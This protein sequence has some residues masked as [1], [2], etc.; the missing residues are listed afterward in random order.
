MYRTTPRQNHVP[1]MGPTRIWCQYWHH[2]IKPGNSSR[3]IKKVCNSISTTE[4]HDVPLLPSVQLFFSPQ[5][6]CR[7]IWEDWEVTVRGNAY[8]ILWLLFP[9]SL[10][11]CPIQACGSSLH[12]RIVHAVQRHSPPS[13]CPFASSTPCVRVARPLATPPRHPWRSVHPLALQRVAHHW[14]GIRHAPEVLGPRP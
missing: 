9:L 8:F 4:E 13:C 2:C 7:L 14:D 1:S 3:N 6:H 10:L 5:Y 11:D 12:P